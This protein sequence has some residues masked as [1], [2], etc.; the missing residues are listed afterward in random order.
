MKIIVSI[1]FALLAPISHAQAFSLEGLMN[2]ALA[3]GARTLNKTV[4]LREQGAMAVNAPSDQQIEIAFSPNAGAQA[5]VIKAI[6]SAKSSIRLAGY[7]FTSKPVLTAL[8]DAK[9]RGVD[10]KLVLDY[11]NNFAECGRR[12]AGMHAVAAAVNAGIDTRVISRY[13]IFHHKFVVIDNRH[14][15]TGS[16]NYSAAAEK[17]N[18]E[19]VIVIWNNPAVAKTYTQQWDRHWAEAQSAPMSY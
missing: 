9:K 15:Q 12:C 18:A 13:P 2:Q 6:R 8:I 16:F 7:S 11:K 19:N 5:L 10:V 1:L 17:S 14:V 3:Q 4:S